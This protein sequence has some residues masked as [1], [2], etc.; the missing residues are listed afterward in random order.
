MATRLRIRR[1]QLFTK[2]KKHSGGRIRGQ[3]PM[4]MS[5]AHRDDC[6]PSVFRLSSLGGRH[7]TAYG[8]GV[9]SLVSSLSPYF[10]TNYFDFWVKM[11]TRLRIRRFQLFMKKMEGCDRGIYISQLR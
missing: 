8:F 7:S 2:N 5:R 4:P 11:A 10:Q 9:F 1:F 3:P 6:L